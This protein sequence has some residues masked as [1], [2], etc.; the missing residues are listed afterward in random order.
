MIRYNTVFCKLISTKKS[1]SE[2]Y[3]DSMFSPKGQAVVCPVCGSSGNCV[4]HGSYRRCVVDY[5]GGKVVYSSIKVR[6]VRCTGCGHT[7]AILPDL[8]IPYTTYSL[9]FILRVLSAYFRHRPVG[10]ICRRFAITP[11]MLYQWKALFLAHKEIWLG[12]L[13]S[14]ETAPEHFLRWIMH[15]PDYSVRF[16]SAFFSKTAYSFLQRH[17]DAARFRHAV[18]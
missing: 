2:L 16:A 6:R 3:A 17:R 8:I 18:F 9:F 13:R 4:P 11:S 10:Q 1:I 12:V 5:I 15:V 7:H 14:A